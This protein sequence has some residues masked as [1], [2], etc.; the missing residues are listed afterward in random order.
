MLNKKVNKFVKNLVKT[1]KVI[2]YTEDLGA[3]IKIHG[4]VNEDMLNPEDYN[5]I[6]L[7]QEKGSIRTRYY[8]NFE[9]PNCS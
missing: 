6:S 8:T 4:T 9:L 7:T 5:F 2:V 1:G 3:K